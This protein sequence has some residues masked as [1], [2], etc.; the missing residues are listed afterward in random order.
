[1]LFI[2]SELLS[3]LSLWI[4]YTGLDKKIEE[5]YFIFVLTSLSLKKELN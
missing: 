3:S 2:I 4:F 1:M 5:I